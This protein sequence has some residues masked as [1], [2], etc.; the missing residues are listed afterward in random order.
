MDHAAGRG[1]PPDRHGR[2]IVDADGDYTD[3]KLQPYNERLRKRFGASAGS[4]ALSRLVPERLTAAVAAWLLESSWFVRHV[5][6]NR[7]FLHADLPAL[8]RT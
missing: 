5:V 2:V 4:D 7:W 8:A 6:L 1:R 3:E